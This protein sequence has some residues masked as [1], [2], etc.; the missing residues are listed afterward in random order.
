M[1]VAA[2]EAAI[3]TGEKR[4]PRSLDLPWRWSFVP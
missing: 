1:E 4:P 3:A 2:R